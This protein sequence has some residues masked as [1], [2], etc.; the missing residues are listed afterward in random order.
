MTARPL[1]ADALDV[2]T[3]SFNARRGM[4]WATAQESCAALALYRTGHNNTSIQK[5]ARNPEGL[6]RAIE[7]GPEAA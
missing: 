3:Q 1:E 7:T 4:N 2:W 6:Y 5:I